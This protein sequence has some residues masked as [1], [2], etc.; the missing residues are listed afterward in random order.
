MWVQFRVTK[1]KTPIF[2]IGW[3]V[4]Q[5]YP[6]EAGPTGCKMSKGDRSVTLDELAMLMLDSL[7]QW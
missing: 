7:H 5:S 6:F 1:V 2:S 4:K 3:L